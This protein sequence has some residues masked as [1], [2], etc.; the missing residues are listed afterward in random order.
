MRNTAIYPESTC[1]GSGLQKPCSWWVIVMRSRCHCDRRCGWVWLFYPVQG[2][3]AAGGWD[4]CLL[5]VPALLGVCILLSAFAYWI[6]CQLLPNPRYAQTISVTHQ[7]CEVFRQSTLTCCC[8]QQWGSA[9]L[10]M[11]LLRNPDL[12][13]ARWCLEEA[14]PDLLRS[15]SLRNKVCSEEQN[16]H[17]YRYR[18]PQNHKV[19]RHIMEAAWDQG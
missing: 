2:V 9:C 16:I 19:C 10:T 4:V 7:S 3:R 12:L 11:C 17:E 5:R 15:K 14:I 13:K 6:A 18:E 8:P 1:S